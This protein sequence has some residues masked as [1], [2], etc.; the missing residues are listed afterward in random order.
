[1]HPLPHAP[2]YDRP[3]WHT[4]LP[5]NNKNRTGELEKCSDG[6][7]K[8]DIYVAAVYLNKQSYVESL[9]GNEFCAVAGR[10]GVRSL[11]FSDATTPIL[12]DHLGHILI[13]FVLAWFIL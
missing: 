2:S 11:I 13:S 6:D 4:Q 9:D 3:S 12:D 8:A 10:P 7:L 5:N 1:M